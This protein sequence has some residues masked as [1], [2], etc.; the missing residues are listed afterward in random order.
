VAGARDTNKMNS[1]QL[2]IMQDLLEEKLKRDDLDVKTRLQM[3][4]M[5]A[6][7]KQEM[8]RLASVLDK[9]VNHR[10]IFDK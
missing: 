2:T 5:L 1:Q 10:E 4:E 8:K 6:E 9:E 3:G 7:V